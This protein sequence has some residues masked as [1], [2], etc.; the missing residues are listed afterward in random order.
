MHLNKD[1]K[2]TTNQI[3]LYFKILSA[4]SWLI[5]LNNI[6]V[7]F[8]ILIFANPV[9]WLSIS[10]SV[11]YQFNSEIRTNSIFKFAIQRTNSLLLMMLIISIYVYAT[12]TDRSLEILLL[13]VFALYTRPWAVIASTLI[14]MMSN[15]TLEASQLII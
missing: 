2:K 11:V 4:N 13:Q 15:D 10:C 5:A 14:L 7:I 3:N 1:S 9:H 6:A 8:N 12:A